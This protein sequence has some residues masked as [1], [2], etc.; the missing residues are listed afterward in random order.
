MPR[1]RRRF[2]RR[3]TASGLLSAAA[4]LAA[5]YFFST[6][7]PTGAA[8]QTA[9]STPPNTPQT[10]APASTR[11]SSP[12]ADSSTSAPTTPSASDDVL[13]IGAWNIE[14]LGKPALRS[15][16]ASNVAQSPEDLAD[17]IR[18][19]NVDVL[20][21]AEVVTTQRGTPIRSPEIEAVIDVLNAGAPARWRYVLF[22]GRAT[23]DQL[24]G[25][26]WNTSRVRA[27]A[28][29]GTPWDER[30]HRPWALP[31]DGTRRSAQNSALWN[32][33]PHAMKFSAG[34]G[35]SD[36]VLVMVHMKADYQGQFAAHRGEEARALVE[37]LPDTRRVFGDQDVVVIGDFNITSEVEPAD[38]TLTAAQFAGL[39]PGR[40]S[41]TWRGGTTDRAFVPIKQPEFASRA[42]ESVNPAFQRSRGIDAR[43]F[44]RR[45]SDHDL[46]VTELRVAQDDD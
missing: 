13:R 10:S 5:A 30:T 4:L 16:P 7:P 43:E 3:T 31:I 44:K 9:Q 33:P 39:N 45:Y 18:F 12:T 15:G 26:M 42:F 36:F 35:R 8:T 23:G 41:T 38:E 21:L 17:V 19:A 14:W 34:P 29:D 28:P 6:R 2:R 20:G 25:V 32:R 40:V 22:P 1:R 24:T 46:I 37:A 11:T 27:L